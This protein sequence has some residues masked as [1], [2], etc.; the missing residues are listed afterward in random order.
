MCVEISYYG[1][2]KTMVP[3]TK[4]LK[5]WLKCWADDGKRCVTKYMHF[6]Q[7][8]NYHFYHEN[9]ILKMETPR[10]IQY[11]KYQIVRIMGFKIPI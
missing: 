4:H 6:I 2:K 5:M 3:I 7:V 11:T 10:R 8:E 9:L 1:N